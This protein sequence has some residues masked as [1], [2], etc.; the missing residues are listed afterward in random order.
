MLLLKPDGVTL[1]QH[2]KWWF[3]CLF[4]LPFFFF[5]CLTWPIV[6]DDLNAFYF[7]GSFESSLN[8]VGAQFVFFQHYY[9]SMCINCKIIVIVL[10]AEV[11]CTGPCFH[12]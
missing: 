11:N 1:T 5:S 10:N 7:D 8:G 12:H 2:I 9:I 6:K 3:G 4:P